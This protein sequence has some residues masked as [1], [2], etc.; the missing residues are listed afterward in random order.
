MFCIESADFEA[1]SRPLGSPRCPSYASRGFLPSLIGFSSSYVSIAFRNIGGSFFYSSSHSF[2]SV[3]FV[4]LK[5]LFDFR[6]PGNGHQF[7]RP[8]SS[9]FYI[10]SKEL[11]RRHRDSETSDLGIERACT[12][13]RQHSSD[14]GL[15]FPSLGPLISF[16]HRHRQGKLFLLSASAPSWCGQFRGL[17]ASSQGFGLWALREVFGL[18]SNRPKWPQYCQPHPRLLQAL[19]PWP[20]ASRLTRQTRPRHQNRDGSG[21]G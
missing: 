6:H 10:E 21:Q 20:P 9:V 4:I 17:E 1:Q 3:C 2:P 11:H 18:T 5:L 12:S 14:Q 19:C 7:L 13:K 16:H 8:I 15:L